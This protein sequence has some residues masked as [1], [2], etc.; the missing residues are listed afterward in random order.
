MMNTKF[1]AGAIGVGSRYGSGFGS[2]KMMRL[3]AV[4]APPHVIKAG[5]K[6]EPHGSV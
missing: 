2:T 3:L 1:R 4:P 5:A 6:P